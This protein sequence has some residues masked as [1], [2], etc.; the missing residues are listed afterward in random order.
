M[1]SDQELT[2]YVESLLWQ[3][4]FAA[5]ASFNV[6]L[7]QFETKLGIDLSRDASFIHHQING[8]L[9]LYFL[10]AAS[11][12]DAAKSCLARRAGICELLA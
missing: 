10:K 9:E 2:F 7:R 12:A 11:A 3:G 1:V 4:C 8:L 6:V 5:F